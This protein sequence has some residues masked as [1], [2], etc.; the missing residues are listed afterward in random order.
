MSLHRLDMMDDVL[1]GNLAGEA[2]VGTGW[3]WAPDEPGTRASCEFYVFCPSSAGGGR[4]G[5]AV[6]PS[7]CQ[8]PVRKVP[9]WRA[10]GFPPFPPG[11]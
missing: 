10:F 3:R 6:P 11:L 9:G 5:G 8:L 7:A 4:T 2:A 1:G